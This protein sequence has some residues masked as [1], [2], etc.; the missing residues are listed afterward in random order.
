MADKLFA[1]V[2]SAA[3]IATKV[4]KV[5]NVV[6]HIAAIIKAGVRTCADDA[7]DTSIIATGSTSRPKKIMMNINFSICEDAL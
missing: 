3:F 6:D 5:G 2:G 4:A 1:Q 7:G